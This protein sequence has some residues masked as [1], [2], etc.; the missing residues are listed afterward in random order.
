LTALAG[1]LAAD[2]SA[3]AR[4]QDG[5]SAPWTEALATIANSGD[6]RLASSFDFNV[7]KSVAWFNRTRGTQL[8]LEPVAG[9]CEGKPTW[10]I[11]EIPGDIAPY[12]TQILGGAA[13]RLS[14]ALSGVYDAHIPSQSPWALYRLKDGAVR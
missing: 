14:Y 12:P 2:A 11:R 5:K 7:G 13:C 6:P 1:S 9:L 10:Y 4:M 8:D 3:I